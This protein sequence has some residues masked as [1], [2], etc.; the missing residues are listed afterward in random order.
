MARFSI[1]FF[2]HFNSVNRTT[3]LTNRTSL[4]VPARHCCRY[5]SRDA[6]NQRRDARISLGRRPI[7]NSCKLPATS[8]FKL[9]HVHYISLGNYFDIYLQ[10]VFLPASRQLAVFYSTLGDLKV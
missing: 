4:K 6:L 1:G 5:R 8:D 9:L 2:Q 3:T 10:K 7:A